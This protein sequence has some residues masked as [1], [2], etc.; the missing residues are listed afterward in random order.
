MRLRLIVAVSLGIGLCFGAAAQ[1]PTCPQPDASGHLIFPDGSIVMKTAL[2]VNPDGAVASYTPGDHGYTYIANGVSLIEDG[3]IKSCSGAGNTNHCHTKWLAAEAAGFGA[4]TAEFCVFA[5]EVEP[6]TNDG[7]KVVCD[8]PRKKRFTAGNGKG[9]PV[10]GA[11]VT[12]VFGRPA[13]TYYSTTTLSHV[14]DGKTVY[15][16]SA[17][18]PGLVAPT[19]RRDLVGAIAWVRYGNHEGFAIINDTGPRFGEGTVALHQLLHTGSVGPLQPVGPIPLDQRCKAAETSLKAPF[20][21]FLENGKRD[22]CTAGHNPEGAVDIRAYSGI[23]KD[24]VSIVLAAVKPPMQG[25]KVTQELTRPL[26][27]QLATNAGYTSAKLSAMARC[28]R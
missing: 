18:I 17:A 10:P 6:L 25:H 14:R 12:D 13:P 22:R 4:G 8:D 24:V 2:E 20:V 26:L 23:D 21:T 19:T 5:M 15:V 7:Q 1:E 28:L 11:T 9:R 3:V 27:S 16:D